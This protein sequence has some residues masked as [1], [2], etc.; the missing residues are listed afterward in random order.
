MPARSDATG[1]QVGRRRLVQGAAWSVPAI[2]V[3]ASAPAHAKSKCSNFGTATFAYTTS[4]TY[5]GT[6]STVTNQVSPDTPYPFVVPDGCSTVEFEII[7]GGG[8]GGNRN[9]SSATRGEAARITGTLALGTTRTVRIYVGRGGKTGNNGNPAAGTTFPVLGGW[10]YGKGGTVPEAFTANQSFQS[11]AGGGGSAI[12]LGDATAGNSPLVVAGGGGGGGWGYRSTE[13]DPNNPCTFWG[14]SSSTGLSAGGGASG[15]SPTAGGNN[16]AVADA[17]GNTTNPDL[18]VYSK[19]GSGA[20]GASGGARGVTATI[21]ETEVYA[22]SWTAYSGTGGGAW[23][24]SS[25]G[26]GDGGYGGTCRDSGYNG[27]Y[28]ITQVWH[29]YTPAEILKYAKST[30]GGGGGGYAGGGGGGA[31]MARDSF[32]GQC[33]MILNPGSG[34]GAGSSYTSAS[35]SGA[36][37]SLGSLPFDT[38]NIDAPGADG[39]VRLTWY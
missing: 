38:S 7:G 15:P 29:D 24:S 5:N 22:T 34:G 12:L 27:T 17:A 19:G 2:A 8:G 39:F 14:P 33:Q 20:S 18:W 32:A 9:T 16:D 6:T 28:G 11:S 37:Y 36:T 10:G 3:G 21:N 23:G 1:R 25:T 30:G 26:G 13:A 31:G 4:Y 35:V